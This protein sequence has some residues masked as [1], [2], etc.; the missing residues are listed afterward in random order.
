[1]TPSTLPRG[2][3]AI[4]MSSVPSLGPDDIQGTKPPTLHVK[5][6]E[7]KESENRLYWFRKVELVINCANLVT[8]RQ[9]VGLAIAKLSGRAGLYV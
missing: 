4:P 9:R 2:N 6:F 7:E 1:M 5:P 8:E 3:E